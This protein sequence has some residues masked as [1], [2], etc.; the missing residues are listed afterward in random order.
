MKL[1][2]VT[3]ETIVEYLRLDDAEETLIEAIKKASIS[4][5]KSY[6]GLSDEEMDK[7]EDLTIAALVLASDMY[8]NRTSTTK[9]TGENKTLQTILSMYAR[10]YLPT[11]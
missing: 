10:N 8:D 9:E 2:E 7:H 6:T 1:S 3:S 11:E 4:Y 5:V